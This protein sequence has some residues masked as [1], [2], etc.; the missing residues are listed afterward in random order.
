MLRLGG[1]P[2]GGK[3]LVPGLELGTKAAPRGL[4]GTSP[5]VPGMGDLLPS[6]EWLSLLTPPYFLSQV[7]N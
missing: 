7:Q 6:T 2:Q 3:T 4:P 5:K 1:P